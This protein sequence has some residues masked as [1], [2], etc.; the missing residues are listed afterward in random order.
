MVY[1]LQ[2]ALKLERMR[3]KISSDLHD[4]VGGILSRLTMQSEILAMTAVPERKSKLE[5]IN[6]LSRQALSRMRDTVWAIDA[7]KDKLAFLLD[8]IREHAEETLEAKDIHFNLRL[9]NLPVDK[10][11][12][13][14]ARQNV[15]LI[16]KEAIANT[17]KYSNGDQMEIILSPSAKKGLRILI[18]D[19]GQV[20]PKST[21]VSGLG[22]SNMRLRAERLGGTFQYS[23]DQ[24]F[25]I[26]VVY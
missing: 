21:K 20:D 14:E 7:R 8:R 19:N 9:E 10:P 24:G 13:A 2:Q 26:E 4:D 15:Y 5:R 16:C 22:L 17:A 25:Q 3:V 11:L 23:V 18:H 12:R 6:N 1:R